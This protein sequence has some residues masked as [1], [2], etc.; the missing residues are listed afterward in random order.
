VAWV[1]VMSGVAHFC[2]NF[3]NIHVMGQLSDRICRYLF[4][5]TFVSLGYTMILSIAR[6]WGGS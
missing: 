2:L 6:Y 5:N 4:L 3:T 1:A